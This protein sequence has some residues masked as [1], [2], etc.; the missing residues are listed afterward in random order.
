[1]DL[2]VQH[3]MICGVRMGCGVGGPII[4][5]TRG[6]IYWISEFVAAIDGVAAENVHGRIWLSRLC[7]LENE[8]PSL[9]VAVVPDP[10]MQKMKNLC[11]KGHLM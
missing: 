10:S 1:M 8:A 3:A 9:P 6:S 5:T 2:E 11:T 7:T 4:S